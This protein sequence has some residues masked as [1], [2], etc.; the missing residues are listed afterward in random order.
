[1]ILCGGVPFIRHPNRRAVL[2]NTS[3]DTISGNTCTSFAIRCLQN[4]FQ[5]NFGIVWM[6]GKESRVRSIKSRKRQRI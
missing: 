2:Y 4:L 6:A 3:I 1:M 5:A